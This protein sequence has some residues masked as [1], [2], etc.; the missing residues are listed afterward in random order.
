[1][2][3]EATTQPAEA[4]PVV[5]L[6]EFCSRLSQTDRRVELIA[7]FHASERSSGRTNGAE[8]DFAARFTA[9]VNKPV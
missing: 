6:D 3:K 9:F 5:T 7:G 2:G 4:A 1:M 8:A